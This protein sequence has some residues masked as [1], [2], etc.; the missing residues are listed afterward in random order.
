MTSH[1]NMLFLD[2]E[3]HVAN[4]LAG[5]KESWVKRIWR[6]TRLVLWLA[7]NVSSRTGPSCSKLMALLVNETLKIQTYC[8]QKHCYHYP[9]NM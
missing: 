9:E 7:F 3:E 8:M 6:C 5:P 4:V 1:A 2:I